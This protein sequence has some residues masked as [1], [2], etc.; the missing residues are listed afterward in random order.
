MKTISR[1]RKGTMVFV[2]YT[3]VKS[4]GE[5]VVK[6]YYSEFPRRLTRK[7]VIRDARA[8]VQILIYEQIADGLFIDGW[9]G[10]DFTVLNAK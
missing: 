9:C 10:D 7:Y 4:N 3:L 5:K 1:A 2:D 8:C 6:H